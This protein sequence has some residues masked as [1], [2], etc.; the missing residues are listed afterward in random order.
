MD[1]FET[2]VSISLDRIWEA[3]SAT[4]AESSQL[5]SGRGGS[6]IAEEIILKA[7]ETTFIG[8]KFDETKKDIN[9]TLGNE[10]NYYRFVGVRYRPTEGNQ[11]ANSRSIE[12]L[13][14]EFKTAHSAEL[15]DAF[16]NIK[17]SNGKNG[18]ADNSCSWRAAAYALYG[19]LE[20]ARRDHFLK[21]SADFS[22]KDSHNYFFWTLFK[23]ET[24]TKLTHGHVNSL[25]SIDPDK[26]M[27]FNINQPFPVQIVHAIGLTQDY[28][29]LPIKQR[30]ANFHS[31]LAIRMADKYMQLEE[32]VIQSLIAHP[33]LEH[34]NAYE[35]QLEVKMRQVA[36]LKALI[37][38]SQEEN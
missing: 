18:Q 26:G 14:I 28:A 9:K 22:D 1:Y 24:A 13:I 4:V 37:E 33:S 6:S 35:A 20:I 5:L 10:G 25:L 21:I 2:A 32:N 34:I 23:N 12:D 36:E 17:V 31:W 3:I 27:R 7:L 15:L 11:E 8:T 16:I 30:R 19:T 29:A 38:K